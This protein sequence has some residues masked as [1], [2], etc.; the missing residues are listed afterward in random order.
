MSQ[1]KKVMSEPSLVDLTGV[2]PRKRKASPSQEGI[3]LKNMSREDLERLVVSLRSQ[4][5]N[6][7][8]QKIS[9]ESSSSSS[10]SSSSAQSPVIS[11]KDLEK[12]RK[13]L[14]TKINNAIKRT[15]IK[16]RTAKPKVEVTA[17]LSLETLKALLN[18]S[19]PTKDTKSLFVA[20][21]SN[22]DARVIFPGI[23]ECQEVV[24]AG[25][26]KIFGGAPVR[27]FMKSV[28]MESFQF[29]YKKKE[30]LLTIKIKLYV[31]SY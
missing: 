30:S 4:L 27:K 7:K 25:H 22:H 23:P 21:I 11:S 15:E 24:W 2:A 17:G 12:L 14:T 18:G 10:S 16:V 13:S 6:A 1:G 5:K 8:R 9:A 28:D 19:T 3:D 31:L 20:D 29:H 26:V